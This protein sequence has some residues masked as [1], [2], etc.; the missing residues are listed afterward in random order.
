MDVIS[1]AAGVIAVIQ[2]ADRVLC[3][4]GEYA[5]AVKNAYKDIERLGKEIKNTKDI[6]EKVSDLL[7]GPDGTNLMAS[8]SLKEAVTGYISE[9]EG[10]EGK[11]RPGKGQ[12]AMSRVGLRALK[13]P[14][15]KNEIESVMGNL[16]RYKQ[17]VIGALQVDQM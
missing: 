12:K 10:I 13:W 11:L 4:C 2:L 9:L 6:L 8:Q 16:E 3:L 14:L 15:Q 17:L 5:T 1:S 7:R